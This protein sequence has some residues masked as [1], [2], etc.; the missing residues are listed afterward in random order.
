MT[1]KILSQDEV[2]ALLKGVASGEIDTEDAKD[3][4]MGGIRAYDF[5]SQERIIRGRMPGLEIA[6]EGFARLFRSSVSSLI[7]KFIDISIQ[8]V[9]IVKFGDFIKAIP[10]PSSI[11]IFKMEPLKGY[12]LFVMEAPLV[13]AFIEFFFGGASAKHIKSEG[14]AFTP[15]EQRVIQKVVKLVLK[16]LGA[17]WNGIAAMQP[18]YVSS[19]IN[20]QFVT[21]VTPAEIVINVEILIEIEDFAGKMFF[22]IPYSMVEPVKEK[23]YSGIHGDKF[24]TD[25][26]WALVMKDALMETYVNVTAEIGRVTTTFGDIMNFEIGA[27]LNLGKSVTDEL[28][29][30]VEG[31]PKFKGTPGVSRGNQ[32][33]KLTRVIE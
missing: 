4:I 29:V 13:F 23:L 6:N 9:E 16:D 2:D 27:V 30:K 12:A 19:E 11:N 8:N 31:L 32:S 14:R 18:E 1:D 17:A 22:C 24:E 26:R 10:V 7:M 28:M 5:T 25:Q 21:I 3:K 20:P 15:I 33:I